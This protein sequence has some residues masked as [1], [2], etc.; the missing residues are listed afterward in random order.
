MAFLL[1]NG[2]DPNVRS[3]INREGGDATDVLEHV[4]DEYRCGHE[5]DFPLFDEMEALLKKYGARS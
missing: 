4:W 2:A 3:Y 1:E 5:E